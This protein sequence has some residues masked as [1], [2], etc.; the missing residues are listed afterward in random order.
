MQQK[1]R[2]TFYDNLRFI[3]ILLVVI[4]HVLGC[5]LDNG[6]FIGIYLFIYAFHMPLFIFVT[7]FFAKKLEDKDGNF[8]LYKVINYVLLFLVFKIALFIFMR[9][10]LHQNVE[11]YLFTEHDTPWFLLSCALWLCITYLVKNVKAKYML[12][13]SVLFALI[14]GYDYMIEDVFVLSRTI[15]FFPFFLLGYHLSKEK[16]N[17]FVNILHERKYQIC[18]FIFLV[19]IITILILFASKLD[20]LRPFLLSAYA[21]DFDIPFDNK[22]M[23]PIIRL[24]CLI[25]SVII[26]LAVMT[27]VPRRRLFFSELG[28]RTLQ[29]YILH[30][31]FIY[32]LLYTRIEMYLSAFFGDLWHV[33]IFAF[34]IILTFLLSFKFWGYPFNKIMKFKYKKIFNRVGD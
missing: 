24:S 15:V 3:L 19:L 12:I 28:K 16:L 10:I 17:N 34:P 33:I 31:F 21:Y 30:L 4:G 11:F 6:Y 9:F 18:S 5:C 1:E 23:F 32:L 26:S 20:F 27:L 13:F 7:G 22:L 14:I 8:K 29:I 2:I 25:T